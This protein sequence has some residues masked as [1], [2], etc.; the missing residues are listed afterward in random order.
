MTKIYCFINSRSNW[1]F[2][3]VALAEDGRNVAG[4]VSSSKGYAMHD[5]GITSDWKHE[6]YKELF[7]EG[8]EL[9]W[10]EEDDLDGHKGLQEACD[11]NNNL[12]VEESSMN[13]PSVE[14][15]FA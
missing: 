6:I 4:H 10:I 14:I 8:Y 3:V 9:E 12:P 5:I 2:E 11:K 15:T 13:Q 7:P 1:G